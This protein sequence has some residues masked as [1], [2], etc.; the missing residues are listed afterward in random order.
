PTP[1]PPPRPA[2]EPKEPPPETQAPAAPAPGET[3]ST[4]TDAAT[5]KTPGLAFPFPEYLRNIV[6]QVYQRWDRTNANDNSSAEVSFLILKD[7]S[8]R[9]IRFMS[10][11]G[12]FSF[13]LDAQGAVEAAG[14]A[15]AFGPLPDGWEADVLPVSIYFKPTR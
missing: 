8:V 11:S 10:R 2:E 14:N 6:N 1:K 15:R 13:D 12:S 3:P 9:E 7:G 5:I 4:G